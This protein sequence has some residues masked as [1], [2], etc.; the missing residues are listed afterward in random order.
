M[1]KPPAPNKGFGVE[2]EGFAI[3][4]VPGLEEAE[5]APNP[6]KDFEEGVPDREFCCC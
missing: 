4:D 2:V 6:L 3:E 5:N 1:P